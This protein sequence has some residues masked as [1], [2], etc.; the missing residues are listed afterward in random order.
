V[1]RPV[2]E[3]AC[4]ISIA[5]DDVTGLWADKVFVDPAFAD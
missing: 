1:I 5:V 2:T 4:S 3:I